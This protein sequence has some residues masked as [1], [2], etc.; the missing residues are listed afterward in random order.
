M[1]LYAATKKGMEAMAHAYA[2]LHGVPTTAFRFF[3]VYGPWGRPDMAL[4][5][6]TDAILPSAGSK[7][8]AKER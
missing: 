1:S 8:M 3:T 6:F 7:C 5:K 2:S 4:F